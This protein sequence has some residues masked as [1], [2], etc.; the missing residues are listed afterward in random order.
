MNA[1]KQKILI[2][3]DEEIVRDTLEGFLT[4]QEHTVESAES[5][6]DALEL[7]A[8]GHFD[9][10]F[11]DIHLP[12]ID[13]FEM[14]KKIRE[15]WPRTRVCLITGYLDREQLDRALES[16]A[17]GALA[18]P[19]SYSDITPLL[20]APETAGNPKVERDAE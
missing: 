15:T 14:L 17:I 20:D 12:G 16:G 5:G 6:E 2:V 11:L 18:K 1:S 19:F 7:L 4:L 10:A 8:R 3:D 13:G 9:F